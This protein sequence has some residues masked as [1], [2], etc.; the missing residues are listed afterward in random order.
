VQAP[1]PEGAVPVQLL[2][3][4]TLPAWSWQLTEAL[5]VPELATGVQVPERVC[6]SCVVQ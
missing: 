1:V 5:A 3:A 6:A 2:L 4:T